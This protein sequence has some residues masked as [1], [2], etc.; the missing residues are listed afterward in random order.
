MFFI[1]K[2]IRFIAINDGI[3][4]AKG[5]NEIM[6]FK[7]VINEYYARDISK[8]VRSAYRTL[9]IN[10]D[11]VCGRAPYGYAKSP[12]DKHKL[13]IDDA[14]AKNVRW[15]YQMA[16]DGLSCQKIAKTLYRAKVIT[17]SAYEFQRTGSYQ[18][19]FDP[20]CPYEWK[21]STVERILGNKVYIGHMVSHKQTTK[22]FK[23]SHLLNIPES[24][25]IIVE[26][27]HAPIID[28]ETFEKV[29]KIL[30]IKKQPNARYN[31][32]IFAGLLI[33]GECGRRLVYGSS[34]KAHG[35]GGAFNC[36]RYRHGVREGPD[37]LCSPH[38]IG[39]NNLCIAVMSNLNEVIKNIYD[40]SDCLESLTSNAIDDADDNRKEL[41]RLTRRENE[42]KTI[43]AKAFERNSLGMIS[44]ETFTDL[45]QGFQ[46]EQRDILAQ[47][48]R[49]KSRIKARTTA[50]AQSDES[51]TKF[52]EISQN[53]IEITKL[54]RKILLDYIEKI[55]IHEANGKRRGKH[56]Q[57][58]K[59][60]YRFIGL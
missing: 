32:N 13:V 44:D 17:P 34:I 41:E 23:N 46:A 9:A 49:L 48:E 40:E 30:R 15:I 33:C 50:G 24:D 7:S 51:I 57:V 27:T 56:E 11:H 29:Q 16:A 47:I 28:E 53:Y 21:K 54:T 5:D 38:V 14:A 20:A 39:Y 37:R 18:S 45:Y 4:S 26:H 31:E 55:V 22:S 52:R 58:I 3:D 1:D 60:Y 42:L 19:R 36:D 2:N 43:I 6:P 8:K 25:W 10:G 12:D 35:G 59:I